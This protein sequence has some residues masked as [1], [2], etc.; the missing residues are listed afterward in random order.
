MKKLLSIFITFC[1]LFSMVQMSLGLSVSAGGDTLT[2]A[3]IAAKNYPVPANFEVSQ[4]FTLDSSG[5]TEEGC[6]YDTA[7]K[8]ITSSGGNYTN[9]LPSK[10]K[11]D[12]S[13]FMFWYKSTTGGIMRLRSRPTSSEGPIVLEASLSASSGCWVKY[14]YHGASGS[15]ENCTPKTDV[16]SSDIRSKVS[17]DEI[18][19]LTFSNWSSGGATYIDEF[20]TFKPIPTP[21][22]TYDNDNQAFKFA[23]SRYA[24]S[25]KTSQNYT[26]SEGA[27]ELVSDYG[28]TT[29]NTPISAT[30]YADADQFATAVAVAKQKSGFL[31]INVSNISCQNSS[32][33]DA[34]ANIVI[35]FGG[36]DKSINE[37]SFGAGTNDDL[38]LNVA[39]LETPEDITTIGI[40]VKGSSIKNVDF[41]FSAITVYERDNSCMYLEAEDLNGVYA[42]NRY[43]TPTALSTVTDGGKNRTYINV[44]SNTNSSAYVEFTLPE[45]EPGE[46]K[47]GVAM[48]MTKTKGTF[49][50]SVNNINNVYGIELGD[51]TYSNKHNTYNDN[52]CTIKITKSYADGPSK[53]KFTTAPKKNQ[54]MCIDY[55]T[56]VKTSSLSAEPSSN[57]V[58]KDYPE[59]QDYEVKKVLDRFDNFICSGDERYYSPLNSSNYV[60]GGY[61]GDGNAFNL[62]SCGSINGGG[63]DANSISSGSEGYLDGDGIRFWYR[64]SSSF[65]LRFVPTSGSREE[66]TVPANSS[67]G[68][69]TIYFKDFKTTTSEK[70]KNIVLKGGTVYI[71]ELHVI[72]QKQGD[73]VYS[74][75]GNTAYVSGYNLRLENIEIASTYQGLPVTAIA[76]GALSNSNTL[77]SVVLP[78]SVTSIGA[79]AFSGCKKLQSINL[80]SNITSIGANAFSGC[81]GLL[82]EVANNSVAKNYVINNSIDYR[83]N[84]GTFDYKKLGSSVKIVEYVGSAKNVTVPA[85]ID[86]VTVDEILENAFKDNTNITG[87]S[88]STVITIGDS[89]FSGCTSLNSVNLGSVVE[90]IGSKS[91]ENVNAL[92]EITLPESITSMKSDTFKNCYDNIT[93]NVVKD[94]YAYT[95]V[96]TKAT[97]MTQIPATSSAFKY[98]LYRYQAT[99]IRYTGSSTVISIPET[100]DDYPV[101]AVGEAAFKNNTTITYVS[102]S[103][104]CKRIYKEAFRGCSS[105]SGFNINR[106]V[107]IGNLGFAFCT[108]LKNITLTNIS[109]Y[110]SDTFLGCSVNI[111]INSV[112][113]ARSAKDLTDTW[114]A[115]INLGN[116][117][118]GTFSWSNA[119]YH[120]YSGNIPT[121][122]TK[123]RIDFITN[124]GFDVIRFP[125]TWVNYVDDSNNYKI[126]DDYLSAVKDVVDY[127]IADNA[128]IIIDVHH[129]V[130]NWLNLSN[131]SDEQIE[132]FEAIWEQ[133]AEYFKD[134]DEH[135][136][137]EGVNELRYKEDWDG[138]GNSGGTDLFNKFNN[139]QKAF[140]DTVR[141]TGGYNDIRYLMLETYGAQAKAGHC[142]KAWVPT[143]EEDDH[144][145][146]SYHFYSDG[147]GENY[148]NNQF[149]YGKSY[150][151]DQG[152]PCIMGEIARNRINLYDGNNPVSDERREQ[153]NQ[154]LYN[155]TKAVFSSAKNH[156]QKVILWEDNGFF[157]M[158]NHGSLA[159]D[160]PLEIEAMR[161]SVY[162]ENEEIDEEEM[163]IEML[164][165]AGASIR[166]GQVNGIR[167][168]TQVDVAKIEELRSAGYTVELGTLIGPEDAIGEELD[169]DDCNSGKAVKV[170]FT[171]SDYYNGTSNVIAGSM[172]SI[173]E[174]TTSNPTSG[175]IARNFVGRGY[176]IVTDSKGNKVYSY[177]EYFDYDVANN[178]R[179][180]AYIAAMYKNDANSSYPQLASSYAEVV[181]RWASFYDDPNAPYE[182]NFPN[183]PA[184][185]DIF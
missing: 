47:L 119:G 98:S 3:Q 44:G 110:E 167:F 173:R 23:P 53:L 90:T 46:Y 166:L 77:K 183:D 108:S 101:I 148:F 137:F 58:V 170:Q 2:P 115:G 67:G 51:A 50:V 102:F 112:Q 71:D 113:F 20:Y 59:M 132:K 146:M 172:T 69:Y 7:C 76:E 17:D 118:D 63:G 81:T 22:D 162:P 6:Y 89:A 5:C 43:A 73:I 29:S 31:K 152:I 96:N 104:N 130:Y 65:T 95:Y 11:L 149:G 161:E 143:V 163:H 26:T 184:L 61:V 158:I 45:L 179:S 16:E 129:D 141:A 84:N 83:C 34:A 134:Y 72:Q 117:F 151:V 107:Y 18:Y 13:G 10:G 87:V 174:Q 52:L 138:N 136:I 19:M 111:S 160:F 25:T 28:S 30:Y 139:I 92:E 178:T 56:L 8:K 176:A 157:G 175:N 153:E 49:I 177:A 85:T 41:K 126:D 57:F 12:G 37:Y 75:S 128:Y 14:Y 125:I 154:N 106:I 32:G 133:I 185:K 165:N 38:L 114:H 39:D 86:S 182:E 93:A 156:D 27:V 15:W 9:V 54:I 88:M 181:D 142:Q 35:T 24:R 1:V 105:L 42:S 124:A 100:I 40:T 159:W 109:K 4:V 36:I 48:Y 103:D 145:M 140:Y 131:Y 60:K 155:W 74:I 21:A 80:G 169:Y 135:L 121:K 99:V 62:N 33:N 78:S 55:F 68:W 171:A 79:N 97:A 122:I 82:A 144:V 94:S 123:A 147:I 150:F 168:T 66:I 120:T 64:S 127:A 164:M 70:V 91:F 180:V 116:I